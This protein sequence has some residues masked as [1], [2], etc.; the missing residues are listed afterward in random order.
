MAL[1]NAGLDSVEKDAVVRLRQFHTGKQ[2]GNDA[3]EQRHVLVT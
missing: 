2:V 1:G 3:L